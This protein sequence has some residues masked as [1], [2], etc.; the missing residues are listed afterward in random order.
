[1]AGGVGSRF[2]P[3]STQDFPKQFHEMLG[4]GKTLLKD[5]FSRLSRLIHSENMIIVTNERYNDLVFKQL[6]EVEKR[7]VDLEQQLR[8]KGPCM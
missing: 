5:T 3:V 1:M 2:W 8:H 7:Q 4:T 6:A